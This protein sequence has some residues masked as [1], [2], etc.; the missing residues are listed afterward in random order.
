LDVIEISDEPLKMGG[1][2]LV[3]VLGIFA[4]IDEGNFQRLIIKEKLTG[5]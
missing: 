5:K 1:I 4:L 3:K 2:Y